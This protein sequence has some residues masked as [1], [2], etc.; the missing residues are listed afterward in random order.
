MYQGRW[1][2][3]MMADFYWSLKRETSENHKPQLNS[4]YQREWIK[5]FDTTK[6]IVDNFVKLAAEI[7]EISPSFKI[8]K[9][10]FPIYKSRMK[11]VSKSKVKNQV[12]YIFVSLLCL[13]LLL[14]M[15]QSQLRD[16][17]LN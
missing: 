14:H 12:T 17:T 13:F 1:D 7:G 2:E 10:F 15:K 4:V 3:H 11:N 6:Y 16:V 8:P 5:E 9:Y